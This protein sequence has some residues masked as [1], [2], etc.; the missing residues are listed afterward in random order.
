MTKSPT[1]LLFSY[2]TLQLE[3]VQIG[4]FGRKLHGVA[5]ALPGFSRSTVKIE[6]AEVVSTS[7]EPD[8]PIVSFSGRDS[9]VVEGMV[10]RITTDELIM[11]DRYEV[12][13]Y[14]RIAATL[15]SGQRAWV[16]VDARSALPP[17]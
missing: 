17:E 13:A 3:A 7:G 11:A 10:F 12:A 15:E 6:N 9:D 2:G 1:E 5:D 16:Y 4:T 14:R 8:H